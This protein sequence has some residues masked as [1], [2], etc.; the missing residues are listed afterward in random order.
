MLETVNELMEL[1]AV[2]NDYPVDSGVP[3]LRQNTDCP[4]WLMDCIV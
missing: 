1:Q 2:L 3:N 4:G